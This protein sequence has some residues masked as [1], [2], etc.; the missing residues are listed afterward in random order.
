MLCLVSDKSHA[1]LL[2]SRADYERTTLAQFTRKVATSKVPNV[3]QRL[4]VL[5]DQFTTLPIEFPSQGESIYLGSRP[6]TLRVIAGVCGDA[7]KA[8]DQGLDVHHRPINRTQVANGLKQLVGTRRDWGLVVGMLNAEGVRRYS[9][10]LDELESVAN[11][12][13]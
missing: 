4:R 11:R 13:A 1:Q 9:Q 7:M 2:A 12:I 3:Q 8:L 6:Q 10:Y 5:E